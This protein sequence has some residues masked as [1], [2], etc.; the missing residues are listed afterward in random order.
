MVSV[1]KTRVLIFRAAAIDE[2]EDG[3]LLQ[4]IPLSMRIEVDQNEALL[5]GSDL[6]VTCWCSSRA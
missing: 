6:V 4:V 2:R 3:D 1:S 5:D